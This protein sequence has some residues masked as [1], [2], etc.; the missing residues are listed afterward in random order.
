MYQYNQSAI[1]LENN[2]RASSSRR[3]KYLNIGYFFITD[4]IKKGELKIEYCTTDYMV[5]DFFTKPLQ[6]NKIL[7]FRKLIMNLKE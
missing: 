6:G 7:Q 2:G 1:L 5:A 3:T 4:C